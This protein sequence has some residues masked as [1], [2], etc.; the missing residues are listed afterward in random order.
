MMN[1][2]P[3]NPLVVDVVGLSSNA[4]DIVG[5]MVV[6]VG[7]QFHKVFMVD[8]VKNEI[9][10]KFTALEKK[11]NKEGERLM[12][13]ESYKV[14]LSQLRD[15]IYNRATKSLD[16]TR[17]RPSITL[18]DHFYCPSTEREALLNMQRDIPSF[19]KYFLSEQTKQALKETHFDIWQWE[20]NEMLVLLEEMYYA[21]NLV[22]ELNIHPAT[23]KR[24]LLR[25][26]ENY[27][28]NPF[29]NFRHSFCVT[30][31]MYVLIHK[32]NLAS[33]LSKKDICVLITSCICHDLDHPGFNNTYQVNA[34]TEIAIRYNDMSPLE[35]H[36]CAMSF[37]ILSQPECNIFANCSEDEFNEIRGDMII[38]ILAT[39][40][41]RHAEILDA[42]KQKVDN[43]DYGCEE[44]LTSLKMILI[45]ACDVSNE[46]R[47]VIVS[48][49]WIECLL[50]EYFH[51][52]DKE[53]SDGLPIAAFMDR[54]RVSKPTAQVAFIRFV[55]LPLFKS[56]QT[57]FPELEEIAIENLKRSLM[58]YEELKAVEEKMKADKITRTLTPTSKTQAAIQQQQQQHNQIQ[59]QESN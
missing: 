22:D 31:M 17:L 40:M 11:V 49:A 9:L 48:E 15:T 44:H 3:S 27:R 7:K 47:P 10:K 59:D 54:S 2:V 43:F 32:C 33:H 34:R 35:N 26:Q 19:E 56:L 55:V 30:Q 25:V 18:P 51:Q 1:N 38:L 45:K 5:S 13:M 37:K 23:L 29:H 58:Y 8:E 52:S 14:D 46:C 12:E 53:R 6:E 21:L 39:D 4:N 24:F 41:S 57:L 16:Y 50:E 28:N 20:P 36:H 42:F